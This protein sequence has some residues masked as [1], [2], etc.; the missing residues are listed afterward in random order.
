MTSDRAILSTLISLTLAL[1]AVPAP[2][3]AGPL[4]GGY[5]GPGE[6]NQAILGSALLGGGGGNGSSGASSGSTGSLSSAGSGASA[7]QSQGNAASTGPS[8]NGPAAG[9]G[10]GRSAGGVSDSRGGDGNTSGGAIG[11]YPALSPGVV[12]QPTSGASDTLGLSDADLAYV[13]LAL[14]ALVFTGVLTRRL[15]RATGPQG[16]Q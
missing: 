4:L 1:V 13:L 7:G 3:L 9:A 2:A 6:G 10:G 8:G 5:G 16:M 11:A 14:F 12:S 15:A